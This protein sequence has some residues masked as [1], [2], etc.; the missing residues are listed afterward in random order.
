MEWAAWQ[1]GQLP[2]GCI[3]QLVPE[4][5]G[6]ASGCATERKANWKRSIF[7]PPSG[8]GMAARNRRNAG[9]GWSGGNLAQ[10]KYRITV[11]PTR[12]LKHR[13]RSWHKY[14]RSVSSSNTTFMKQKVNAAWPIIRCA[15]GT[16]GIITWHW[17]CWQ[18]SFWSSKRYWDAI[19]GQCYP[20][21]IW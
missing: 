21:M 11:Y 10:A 19:N 18:H 8:C 20:S 7:T 9:T 13:Y 4:R 17:S 12:H 16:H 5:H 1:G 6:G 3:C 14:K 2:S 15:D